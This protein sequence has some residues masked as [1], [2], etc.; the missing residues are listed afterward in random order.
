MTNRMIRAIYAIVA[1]T[2][3]GGVVAMYYYLSVALGLVIGLVLGVTGVYCA[4]FRK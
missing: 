2:F 4:E 3:M 1:A